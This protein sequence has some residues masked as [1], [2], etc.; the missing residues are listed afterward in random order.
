MSALRIL[1][2]FLLA[3]A[4]AG[5]ALPPSQGNYSDGGSDGSDGYSY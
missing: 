3:A 2:A 5:C 1:A 4:L